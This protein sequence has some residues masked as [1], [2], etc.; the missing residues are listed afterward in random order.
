MKKLFCLSLVIFFL[1][2]GYSFAQISRLQF[3]IDSILESKNAKVGVSFLGIEDNDAPIKSNRH[4]PMQSVYKFHLALKVLNE[5]DKGTFKRD[6][7]IFVAKK[8]LLLNLWSPLRE[9]YPKGDTALTLDEILSFTVSESDNSGCD[10]LFRLMGGPK[11][12]ND[13]MHSLGIK[14]INIIANEETMQSDEKVQ[15]TN[16]TTPSAAVQLLKKFY[17]GKILS[18][19]NT[20]FLK[21]LMKNTSTGPKRIKGLL[22]SE[23]DVMHKTGSSGTN[24]SRLTPATNDIGI[25]TLPNGKH[26]AI[27]VFVSDSKENSETNERIIAEIAKAGWDY[28]LNK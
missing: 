18:N 21:G 23:T 26:F 12:V 8:D 22:P 25:V 6:Q 20:E 17:Q 15:Y 19:E 10:L 16:W 9:K 24:K 13:F 1:F 11:K 7:K 4:Y 5:V 27:A 28:F 2:H 3:Q 14:D